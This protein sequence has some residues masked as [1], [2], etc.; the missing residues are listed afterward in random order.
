[1]PE[2]V[3]MGA[4]LKCSMGMSPC[5]LI[6]LPVRL[7]SN[8]GGATASAN[9][10]DYP[11]ANIPTFGMCQSLG[12][13]TVSAATTAANGVLTPMPCLPNIAAPWMPGSIKISIAGRAAL[14]KSDTC[15]CSY[16][17]TV[18]ITNAGQL[19]VTDGS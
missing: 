18:T 14:M 2:Q 17:G 12:N 13:P 5:S 6:V 7:V 10:D 16:G 11:V 15:A 1:M 8:G 4:T 9:V 3:A 19:K